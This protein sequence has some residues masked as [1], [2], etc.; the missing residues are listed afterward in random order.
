MKTLYITDLDGTLLTDDAELSRE[1]YEILQPLID[2]G[3]NFT[4]ATA[5]SH[6]SALQIIEPL[7]LKLPIL[8]HNGTFIYD[9]QNNQFINKQTLPTEDISCIIDVAKS[10]ELSPFIYTLTQK[11]AHVYYS[12]LN[13]DA[14]RNYLNERLLL[15]DKRFIEDAAYEEYKNEDAYYISVLGSQDKLEHIRSLY[16]E[17]E[18]VEISLT[19]DTYNENSWWLEIMPENAGKG[20]AIEYLRSALK[21]ERIV[22]F[23]DNY[24]DLTMF[25]KADYGVC[26]E[27]SVLALQ[28]IAD[29]KIG[30][31]NMHSVAKF[32]KEDFEKT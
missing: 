16:V 29:H 20:N 2:K 17:V 8:C 27:R 13:N 28:E 22:C 14:E 15:G 32:I 25:E 6:N 24:N 7:K 30:D 4:I 23:G 21:P 5:R 3:L 26:V 31:N 10:Y 11:T 19:M 1:S 18:G 12:K 9:H